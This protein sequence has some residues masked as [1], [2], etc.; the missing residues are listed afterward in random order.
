[1]RRP[2]PGQSVGPSAD[3]DLR[4][5][6]LLVFFRDRN[7][8]E[9]RGSLAA[10]AIARLETLEIAHVAVVAYPIELAVMNGVEPFYLE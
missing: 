6:A 1:M 2:R 10:D 7:F 8:L 3:G 5:P 9:F 4:A